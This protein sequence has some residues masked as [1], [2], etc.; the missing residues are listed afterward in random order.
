MPRCRG[1]RCAQRCRRKQRRERCRATIGEA[2]EAAG[3]AARCQRLQPLAVCPT[4]AWPAWLGCTAHDLPALC[5]GLVPLAAHLPALPAP[6]L[7][8]P[9]VPS[10]PTPPAPPPCHLSGG[11]AHACQRAACAW[12]H[13]LPCHQ[14]RRPPAPP[15]TAQGEGGAHRERQPRMSHMASCLSRHRAAA[16][17]PT[18]V[19]VSAAYDAEGRTATHAAGNCGVEQPCLAAAAGRRTDGKTYLGVSSPA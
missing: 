2:W 1:A 11:S 8:G 10:P 5:V 12:L 9:P 7:H 17:V 13:P 4:L 18:C 6:P 14:G 15:P 3:K 16:R 19:H